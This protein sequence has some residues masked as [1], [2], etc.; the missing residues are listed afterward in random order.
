MIYDS[1]IDLYRRLWKRSRPITQ[2]YQKAYQAKTP[3]GDFLQVE[4]SFHDGLVK[5]QVDPAD[6]KG[7]TYTSTIKKGTII[8]ERD[9]L[10]GFNFPLRKKF[11]PYK[12]IF[13]CLPD[14]D[15]LEYIGGIYD[16]SRIPLF[17]YRENYNEVDSSDYE[18]YKAPVKSFSQKLKEYFYG[19]DRSLFSWKRFKERVVDDIHDSV[20]GFSIAGVLYFHFF[21]YMILGWGLAFLGIFF[22]GL[23]WIL[24]NRD[25]MISKVLIFLLTGSYFFYTGYTQF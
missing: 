12:S 7:A 21:D 6:E 5:L 18:I 24:R 17:K 19:T 14:E 4:F 22:G 11:L 2:G 25:P 15:I 8:R 9:V 23:D 13:S 16:I 10:N 1:D 3:S 20:L